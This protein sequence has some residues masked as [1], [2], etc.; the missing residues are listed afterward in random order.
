M[1]HVYTVLFPFFTFK[2]HTL[3]L[4]HMEFLTSIL[5]VFPK[6]QT[7]ISA[8]A[9][10]INM[11]LPLFDSTPTIMFINHTSL[12]THFVI[13]YISIFS[14]EFVTGPHC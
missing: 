4:T 2:F 14:I 3:K 9:D 8:D 10:D 6:Q 12:S 11:S 7:G 5:F 13:V 1:F